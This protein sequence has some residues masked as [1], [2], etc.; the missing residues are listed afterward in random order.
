MAER[1]ASAAYRIAFAYTAVLALG[2]ALLGGLVY[3]SMHL[4]LTNQLDAAVID[5]V[6]TIITEYRDDGGNELSTAIAQ[7]EASRSPTR[8]RYAVFGRDGRKRFGGLDTSRP[9]LGLHDIDFVDAGNG[10]DQA[11]AVAVDLSPNERL[12]V[13]ADRQTIEEAD[14]RLI[15][16]FGAGLLGVGALGLAGALLLGRYLRRRLRA[17]SGGAEAI[18]AGDT[19]GRMPVSDRRDEFDDLAA[20]LNRMLDRIEGLLDNLRQVSSDIAHDLRT[21]LARLRNRLEQALGEVGAPAVPVIEDA[22]R[23]VDELLALFT[24]ILRIAEVEAGETRKYFVPV[25]LSAIVT[26]LA[27]TYGDVVRDGGRTLASAVDPGLTIDGDR[28]LI[29]QAVINL[30]EN[31]QRHTPTETAIRLRLSGTADRVLLTVADNGPGV[32]A[33]D[34]ERIVERFA[35]LDH[36]R[37]TEGYGL[38]LNL[39][40]A[41]ARLHGGSLTFSDA[42][43]GLIASINFPRYRPA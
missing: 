43:P 38:G 33:A 10:P 9:P 23:R 24:A 42:V 2:V 7:R 5:E 21:P 35:R 1:R 28:S 18:I 8:L 39:V 16:L 30:L 14:D 12:V 40:R 22:T 25:D 27:E 20:T 34:R 32:A 15:G 13:A 31:A 37:H 26:D 19:R 17:I 6:H 4:A 29:A 3:W 36:S 41:V 11:R